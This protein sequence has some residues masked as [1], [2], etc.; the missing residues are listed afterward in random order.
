MFLKRGAAFKLLSGIHSVLANK[1][2][3][4]V[5]LK[6]HKEKLPARSLYEKLGYIEVPAKAQVWL[7]KIF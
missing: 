3:E 2:I 6:V 1:G 4:K 7:S 5:F